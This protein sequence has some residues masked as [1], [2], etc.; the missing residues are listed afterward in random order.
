[1]F[2]IYLWLEFNCVERSYCWAILWYLLDKLILPALRGIRL[3]SRVEGH[4]SLLKKFA[5]YIYFLYH[6]IYSI[7]FCR[8]PILARNSISYETI[9]FSVI[10][11]CVSQAQYHRVIV[12]CW[13]METLSF[14]FRKFSLISSHIIFKGKKVK[15]SVIRWKYHRT[16]WTEELICFL[17]HQASNCR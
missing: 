6:P 12:H 4:W 7:F 5:K 17:L 2:Y 3:P 9:V 13:I 14:K 1:M 15:D 8:V 11:N 16:N 10:G